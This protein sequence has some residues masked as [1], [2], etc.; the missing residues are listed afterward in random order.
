MAWRLLWCHKCLARSI[1]NSPEPWYKAFISGSVL[2]SSEASRRYICTHIRCAYT[3]VVKEW[4][5]GLAGTA[6]KFPDGAR[7]CW[8][9]WWQV[10]EGWMHEILEERNQRLFP[11]DT[12]IA[13]APLL[14]SKLGQI[15]MKTPRIPGGKKTH[16][17][18]FPLQFPRHVSLSTRAN[19]KSAKCPRNMREA[20]CKISNEAFHQIMPWLRAWVWSEPSIPENQLC[21]SLI[22]RFYFILFKCGFVMKIKASIILTNI[23]N[24]THWEKIHSPAIL[25]ANLCFYQCWVLGIGQTT[26]LQ[27]V[28]VIIQFIWCQA[29]N[30]PRLDLNSLCWLTRC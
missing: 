12:L 11:S 14:E 6:M 28:V 16:C 4:F 8:H 7:Y 1:C 13:P 5:S 27:H 29:G 15:L 10:K 30:S 19:H 20:A 25:L 2:F 9:Q 17:L 23:S 24:T 18:F 3:A 26:I 22:H 21:S